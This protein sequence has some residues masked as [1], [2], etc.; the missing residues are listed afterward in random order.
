MHA[1]T[2]VVSQI[3]PSEAEIAARFEALIPELTSRAERIGRA[4]ARNPVDQEEATA[5]VIAHAWLNYRSAARRGTWLPASQLAWVA[6]H[7]TRSGRL[8]AGGSS[9]TDVL[10]PRAHRM[11]RASVVSL[12]PWQC[13]SRRRPRL[14]FHHVE[15]ERSSRLGRSLS[16]QE[17][18]S[19]PER[20]RVRLDWS[21]FA[22]QLSP[23]HRAILCGLAEGWEQR[24]MAAALGISPGRI[25]QQKAELAER[26]IE[27][28]DTNVPES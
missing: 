21:A 6:W 18:D 28:F 5:E 15:M 3:V 16:T 8:A 10:D 22:E 24:E 27:F 1:D 12:Y 9:I 11:G 26:I 25:T 17:K 23:R 20:V 7:A 4:V 2:A 19:P 13:A 14:R